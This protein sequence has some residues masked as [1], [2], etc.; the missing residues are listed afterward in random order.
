M[1]LSLKTIKPRNPFVVASLRRSAGSH[2]P[3][4]GARRQQAERAVRQEVSHLEGRHRRP[5]P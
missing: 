5:T 2:R 3:G 1:K 4:P